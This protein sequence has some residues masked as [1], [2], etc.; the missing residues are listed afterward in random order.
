MAFCGV[1]TGSM[2]PNDAAKVAARPGTNG[3]TFAA[4]AI[5]KTIGTTTAADA[6]LLVV[7]RQNS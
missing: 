1:D 5:G 4:I 6:V 2:K 3:S 7:C